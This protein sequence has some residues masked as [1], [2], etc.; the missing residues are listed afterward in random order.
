L[1]EDKY[2]YDCDDDGTDLTTLRILLPHWMDR[3]EEHAAGFEQ[4]ADRASAAGH[5]ETAQIIL[6]AAEEMRQANK[7]LQLALESLGGPG[8]EGPILDRV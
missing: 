8:A 7:S 1:T 4:W 6:R 3:N 5:D 2:L